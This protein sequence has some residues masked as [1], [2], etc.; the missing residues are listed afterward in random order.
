MESFASN[1]SKVH[2]QC[3]CLHYSVLSMHFL[4]YRR[5]QL[6]YSAHLQCLS[7]RSFVQ[8]SRAGRSA[9]LEELYNKYP[10]CHPGP[11]VSKPT[12]MAMLVRLF[13]LALWW[14]GEIHR[15][16]G[17]LGTS[18]PAPTARAESSPT[19]QGGIP[20][21]QDN[22]GLW[23]A[24]FWHGPPE[25]SAVSPRLWTRLDQTA[26]AMRVRFLF[27]VCLNLQCRPP[28]L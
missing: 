5:I 3:I 15:E 18:S 7:M 4:H 9:P 21:V 1:E 28:H 6:H 19:R 17:D 22:R 13:Q 8:V 26:I 14:Q 24:Q 11:H 27:C 12:K 16:G 10:S 23:P 20:L 2:A 25:R